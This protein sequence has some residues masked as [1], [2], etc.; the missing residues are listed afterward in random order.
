MK[1]KRLMARSSARGAWFISSAD[2]PINNGRKAHYQGRTFHVGDLLE[3]LAN[4][5][6]EKDILEQHSMLEK[7][8]LAAAL[9]YASFK[10]KNTVVIRAA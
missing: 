7:E 8:D 5:L 9:H 1:T 6:S 2:L 3:L 4:G 10:M